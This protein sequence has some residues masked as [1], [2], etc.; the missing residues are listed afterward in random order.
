[1]AE[2]LVVVFGA[3]ALGELSLRPRVLAQPAFALPQGGLEIEL[4]F[5]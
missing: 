1:M 5:Q 2:V 4:Q 3:E